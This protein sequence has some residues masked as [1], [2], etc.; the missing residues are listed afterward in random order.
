MGSIGP[1]WGG[2]D[3]RGA[4]LRRVPLLAQHHVPL[5]QHGAERRHL[6]LDL[7][8]SVSAGEGGHK[9]G[10]QR[11][12]AV[13]RGL[14]WGAAPWGGFGGSPRSWGRLGGRFWGAGAAPDPRCR[15]GGSPTPRARFGGRLWGW[16]SAPD[17]SHRLWGSPTPRA[18]FGGRFWGSGSAQPPDVGLGAAPHPELDLG[19]GCGSGHQPHDPRVSSEGV[20]EAGSPL[21]L[22]ELGELEAFQLDFGYGAAPHPGPG[23]RGW[24]QPQTPIIGHLGP[25]CGA[26]HQP[27]TPGSAVRA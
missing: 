22:H 19:P 7:T 3:S 12:T 23:F 5:Q 2:G 24:D 1:L 21:L 20:C 14:G 25:G 6:L 13:G 16:G 11:P 9:G 27:H 17:P 4:L 10:G 26:G 18:G 8:L 15:L